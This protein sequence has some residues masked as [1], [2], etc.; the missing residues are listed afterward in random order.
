MTS[1]VE[2]VARAIALANRAPDSDDWP[3]YINDARA[4]IAAMANPTDAMIDAAAGEFVPPGDFI[5]GYNAAIDA[6]LLEQQA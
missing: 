6:A 5:P 2:K 1:M 3:V 4:A